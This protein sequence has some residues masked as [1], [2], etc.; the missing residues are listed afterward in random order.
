MYGASNSKEVATWSLA[1]D[2]EVQLLEQ[3]YIGHCYSANHCKK[4]KAVICSTLYASYFSKHKVYY[5]RL[6]LANNYSHSVL[7]RRALGHG[8]KICG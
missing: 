7:D 5:L 2:L 4:K 1:L 6:I 8:I 3:Q